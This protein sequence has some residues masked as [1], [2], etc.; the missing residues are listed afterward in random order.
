[1]PVEVLGG[2]SIHAEHSR[3]ILGVFQQN[4]LLSFH[5]VVATPKPGH[6]N[7]YV[8]KPDS[9]RMTLNQKEG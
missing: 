2:F 4:P 1:M 8:A 5:P 3:S 7:I 9:F 6:P